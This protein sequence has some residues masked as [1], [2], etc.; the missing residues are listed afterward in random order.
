VNILSYDAFVALTKFNL[1]TSAM[2][3]R[4]WQGICCSR[5]HRVFYARILSATNA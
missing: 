1:V 3:I 2:F 5:Y 4:S